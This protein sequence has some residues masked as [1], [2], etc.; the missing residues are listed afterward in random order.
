[1]TG[2]AA[3][4]RLAAP[5]DFQ[6]QLST[7]S[8]TV[9]QVLSSAVTVSVT[10]LN[11]FTG[12]VS[13]SVSDAPAGFYAYFNPALLQSGASMLLLEPGSAVPGTYTLKV[14]GVG[15][16]TVQSANLAVTVVADSAAGAAYTW[17][18]YNPNLDYNFTNEYAAVNPPTNILNDCSGVTTTITMP[19][20]WFC[21][22]FGAGK[23]SLVTSN[24]WIPMLQR[25]NTDFAYFR[26]VMGWPPDKRAKQGYYSSV[27][28]LGS[29]TCVGGASND[30]G[31]WMGSIYSSG[32][33][34]PMVL[35]SYYP[36]YSFD[37]ACTYSDKVAQQGAVVH[38]AI[39]SVLA[40]LP[41][42]KQACWFQEG[43]NTWLQ[44]GRSA[45]SGRATT[46]AWAG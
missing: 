33:D 11:G 20:N 7:S 6:I 27:Y 26:E 1:M 30:L 13:L 42:C 38:E 9:T 10:P 12:T 44:K 15:G 8:L 4:F 19:S 21:F 31:G 28:L 17:P 37:P 18:S 40:G 3:F 35:L 32:Q 34:W 36:V 24:A 43:G 46:A 2:G 22:R 39:H 14:N 25:L 23:H 5:Q 41:G 29:G 45:R 16:F